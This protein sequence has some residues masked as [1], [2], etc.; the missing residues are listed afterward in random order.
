MA[1]SRQAS[2]VDSSDK[3]ELEEKERRRGA[4]YQLL[5]LFC[6]IRNSFMMALLS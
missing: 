3:N 1:Q 5:L 4:I 2:F 6:V